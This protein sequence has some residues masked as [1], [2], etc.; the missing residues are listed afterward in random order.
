MK[1]L[2]FA[3]SRELSGVAEAD[4]AI[5]EKLSATEVWDRLIREYPKL[6]GLRT[7]ARLAQNGAYSAADSEFTNGDEVAVIPPVSGG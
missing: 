1:V 7:S 2:F 3:G 4:L 6:A 5:T